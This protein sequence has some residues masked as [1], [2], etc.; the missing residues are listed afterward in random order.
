VSESSL[1]VMARGVLAHR[2]YAREL[3]SRLNKS[4]VLEEV[5][6]EGEIA[7]VDVKGRVDLLV[8]V[9]DSLRLSRGGVV[10]SGELYVAEVKTSREISRGQIAQVVAYRK[11]LDADAIA[12]AICKSTVKPVT[13]IEVNEVWREVKRTVRELLNL[14]DP[15]PP[16]RAEKCKFCPL[17]RLK[18]CVY[19]KT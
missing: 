11:L 5:D 13:E 8:L 6:V 12:L 2:A 15:P 14:Y 1:R 7:G 18:I 9:T 19:A 3:K 10:S 16:D 4:V 17:A